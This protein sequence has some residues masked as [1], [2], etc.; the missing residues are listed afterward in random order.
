MQEKYYTATP[1]CHETIVSRKKTDEFITFLNIKRVTGIAAVVLI[2][3]AM[4]LIESHSYKYHYLMFG[5]ILLTVFSA[6]YLIFLQIMHGLPSA[7]PG[8][9]RILYRVYWL[10]FM[11]SMIPFIYM[12]VIVTR[13]PINIVLFYFVMVVGPVFSRP[14]GILIFAGAFLSVIIIVILCGADTMFIIRAITI[15]LTATVISNILHNSYIKIIRCLQ[16]E[17]D[18]DELTGLLNRRA[19]IETTRETLNKF[20]KEGRTCA[21][22]ILDIDFFKCYNDL[23]SH[24]KGDEMLCLL[25][26][27][28]AEHINLNNNIL[29]RMGGDEFTVFVG[30]DSVN[31]IVGTAKELLLH[32][33]GLGIKSANPVVSP[34]MTVSIGIHLCPPE[35]KD[36]IS[37]P[38]LISLLIEA[39][40][41]L[42]NAKKHGRNVI[43]FDNIIYR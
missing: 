43:S 7:T 25:A 34:V 15:A 41:Q 42:Y 5:I 32:V 8:Q 35:P 20:R 10:L 1:V 17:R 28:L 13:I 21:F 29:Y 33:S 40:I 31:D 38:D 30:A 19:G 14:E 11:V 27:C 37:Q 22:F 39:D 2:F 3:Q 18:T 36:S 4:N 16:I 6:L 26:K 23:Y 9:F 12:D 24:M